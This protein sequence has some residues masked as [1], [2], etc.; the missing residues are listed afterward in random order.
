MNNDYLNKPLYP[1]SEY[2]QEEKSNNQSKNQQQ[3]NSSLLGNLSSILGGQGGNSSL[4]SLLLGIKGGNN[5]ISSILSKA[6][7]SNPLFQA[8]STFQKNEKKESKSSPK[9]ISPDEILF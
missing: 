2:S 4:L 1:Q 3:G 9:S 8:L 7:D 6:G 5:G